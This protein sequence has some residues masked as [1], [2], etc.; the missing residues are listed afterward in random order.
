MKYKQQFFSKHDYIQYNNMFELLTLVEEL[1]LLELLNMFDIL[2]KFKSM[3]WPGRH[4]FMLG[5]GHFV[6][7]I[8]SLFIIYLSYFDI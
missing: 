6:L 2:P 1:N 8:K 7:K 3:H 5:L 4:L